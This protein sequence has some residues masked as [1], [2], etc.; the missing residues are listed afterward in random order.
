MLILGLNL[1]LLLALTLPSAAADPELAGKWKLDLERSASFGAAEPVEGTY[2]VTLQ[3][4]DLKMER[5]GYL[6]GQARVVEWLVITDGKAHDIP[7]LT[8]RPRSTRAKWKK[9]KLSLSYSISRGG[10]DI[11]INEI[12]AI[13]K[14][15]ELEIRFNTRMAQQTRTI[16]EYWVRV[17]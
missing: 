11:D 12:W 15:G 8:G 9:D 10:T 7:G 14:T 5:T 16:T 4:E 1:V 6:N 3:G 17:E 2:E 13:N